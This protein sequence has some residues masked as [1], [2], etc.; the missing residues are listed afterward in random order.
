MFSFQ[1][2]FANHGKN[3]RILD[4]NW[5]FNLPITSEMLYFGGIVINICR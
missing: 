5:L 2:T 3:L 1:Y 4:A